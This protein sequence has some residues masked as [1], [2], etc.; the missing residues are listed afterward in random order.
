MSRHS[1]YER[2]AAI[3]V[4]DVVGYGSFM[5]ENQSQVLSDLEK[6][7][8]KIIEPVIASCNGN[9]IKQTGDGYLIEFP[10]SADALTCATTWQSRVQL[11]S[12][13]FSELDILFRIGVNIGE[14]IFSDNDIYGDAVNIAARLES[15]CPPG[16]VCVS[17]LVKQSLSSHPEFLFSNFG[18]HELKNIKS[19]IETFIATSNEPDSQSAKSGLSRANQSE[20]SYSL[21]ADG[22]S[23]AHATVGSGYPLVIAGFWMTHL[24]WDW[25]SPS[26]RSYLE[27]LSKHY[28]IIRYDQRGNGMSDWDNVD[29]QFERMVDDIEC[30]IDQYD[31][32]SVAILGISQGA[33]V[34]IGYANRYPERVSHLVLYGGYA[35][36]RRKR[37]NQKDHE[38]SIALVNLIR[39]GWGAENPAFR[40]TLTSLFM[41]EA[42]RDE[43]NWFKNFPKACG[44]AEKMSLFREVFDEMDISSLLSTATVPTLIAHCDGDS[45]APLSEGKY[46]A[47]RI[48]NARFTKFQSKNHTMFGNE[49]DFPKLIKNICEFVK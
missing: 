26:Y 8:E 40:Q 33:S 42:T 5:G 27:E 10:S 12:G 14:V 43:A 36:G 6:I 17:D 41:P 2:L 11:E 28:Q 23:I 39:H 3:L 4:A 46:L 34:A 49:K 21:S 47:S 19:P 13:S 38:E 37:N 35:R 16:K 15:I 48:P 29:I 44:P 24:E 20:V 7:R 22:T 45:I 18:S 25:D 32:G 1:P 9:F 31:H 30:V